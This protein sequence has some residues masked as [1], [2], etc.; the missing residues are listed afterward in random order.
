MIV[1][2]PKKGW[3]PSEVPER[4]K[5][6][7]HPFR[8]YRKLN[9]LTMKQMAALLDSDPATICRIENWKTHPVNPTLAKLAEVKCPGIRKEELCWPEDY[10]IS[11]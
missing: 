9:G 4:L 1:L 6:V 11:P 5:G 7:V 2:M 10:L 8:R 3:R